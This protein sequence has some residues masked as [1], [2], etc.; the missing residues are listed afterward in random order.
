M[1][2]LQKI[3][4]VL[5]LGSTGVS[6]ALNP[7]SKLTSYYSDNWDNCFGTYTYTS[8]NYYIGEFRDGKFNGQG[9]FTY[10]NGNKYI[11]EFK[12]DEFNG[13]GTYTYASGH[14]KKGI[15]KD[16]EFQYAT[17]HSKYV[18][19]LENGRKFTFDARPGLTEEEAVML[20]KNHLQ[21]GE[22]KERERVNDKKRKFL[23]DII[24]RFKDGCR[25]K[26][27]SGWRDCWTKYL[28]SKC[29]GLVYIDDIVPWQQCVMSC[30]TE[31]V[32]SRTFGECSH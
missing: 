10:A 25:G 23:K 11:G 7:C 15:W 19:S 14:V 28:P 4:F 8:G 9:T 12:D 2:I 17:G 26:S 3:C 22:R 5:L 31:S 29:R 18:I 20:L 32:Y 13:Q 16:D 27:G 21:E 6:F 24:K 30:T 1:K